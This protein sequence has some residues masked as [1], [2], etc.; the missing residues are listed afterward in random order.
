[1]KKK[2]IL[3]FC[4]SLFLGA[5]PAMATMFDFHFGSLTTSWDGTSSFTTSV[6]PSTTSGSVQ[7]LRVPTATAQFLNDT[8]LPGVYGW[9]AQGGNF[10]LSMSITGIT[11]TDPS[12]YSAIGIGS[13][14]ITDTN[15]DIIS[16]NVSGTWS[17]PNDPVT[18]LP[19]ASNNFAG[20][21]SNVSFAN[22]TG[23]G[24]FDGHL[25]SASMSYPQVIPWRGSLIQLS[26]TGGWFSAG[27]YTTDSGSVDA[28]VV[29]VPG[30]VLLGIIGLGAV[31]VK[32]RK[33]A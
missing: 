22:N 15:G 14:A 10:S 25:G 11:G 16:G 7:R 31:G 6:N 21:L 24:N 33:L 28:S 4:L 18:G 29:P 13:W 8:L 1:M 23:D 32:L 2:L 17:R 5:T 26:T 19:S 27:A 3:V 30:A 12:S 20:V 9:T